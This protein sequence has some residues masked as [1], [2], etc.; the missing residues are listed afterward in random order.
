[1]RSS[2]SERPL[3]GVRSVEAIRREGFEGTVTLIG[4]E[5]HFP[6]FDRPPLSKEVLMGSWEPERA[7]LRIEEDLELDLL[8][9]LSAERLDLE[10]R[11]VVLADGGTR[12]FDGLVI[13]TGAAPRTMSIVDPPFGACSCCGRSATAS[14][15]ERVLL[16]PPRSS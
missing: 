16:E 12:H 5:A 9:G 7:R 8:L 13:A 3:G 10:R 15:F 4:D 2:L 11:E 14:P 6:P 1:M